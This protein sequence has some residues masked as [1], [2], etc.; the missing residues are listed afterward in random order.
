MVSHGGF[1]LLQDASRQISFKDLTKLWKALQDPDRVEQSN[2]KNG[3]L[4]KVHVRK[5]WGQHVRDIAESDASDEE[6]TRRTAEYCFL[7]YAAVMHGVGATEGNQ[8]WK[9]K[10]NLVWKDRRACPAFLDP[11][12]L[13]KKVR[14][15]VRKGNGSKEYP[16]VMLGEQTWEKEKKRRK[17]PVQLKL[18]RL[19]CWLG[20]GEP[21]EKTGGSAM[22][23][24]RCG[25]ENCLK[26]S[27]FRWGDAA[28]NRRHRMEHEKTTWRS[29]R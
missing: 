19:A 28:L 16:R 5:P 2:D 18:H 11:K 22:A 13:P 4:I 6:K 17:R 24:H 25:H 12:N 8:P 7:I 1:K 14:V 23:L 20:E 26:L 3:R 29:R 9:N 21:P 15:N 10:Q 27:C